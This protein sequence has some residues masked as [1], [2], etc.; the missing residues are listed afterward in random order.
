MIRGNNGSTLDNVYLFG[1]HHVFMALE[2]S[3][4]FCMEVAV[5][6]TEETRK[7]KDL[8]YFNGSWT[9]TWR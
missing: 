7:L 8:A 5:E 2:L 9:E 1:F 3:R 4:N 6:S